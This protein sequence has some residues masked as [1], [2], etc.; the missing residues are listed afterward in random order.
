MLFNISN[1]GLYV[2]HVYFSF[3]NLSLKYWSVN[4]LESG[5]RLVKLQ[6]FLEIVELLEFTRMVRLLRPDE[7]L[8]LMSPALSLRGAEGDEAIL[9][10][11][12]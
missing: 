1:L 4:S 8:L 12:M 11:G 9:V 10:R 6:E 2:H 5:V 7:S 3:T